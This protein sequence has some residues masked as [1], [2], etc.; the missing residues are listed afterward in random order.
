MLCIA[1]EGASG[2]K[3]ISELKGIN[4]KYNEGSK[5][6]RLTIDVGHNQIIATQCNISDAVNILPL[7]VSA[8][9]SQ[10][11]ADIKGK[12]LLKSVLN[13]KRMT[14]ASFAR[15]I[16]GIDSALKDAKKMNLPYAG[17]ILDLELILVDPD[18]FDP[19]LVHLPL[20]TEKPN[21]EAL[22]VFIRNLIY[23]DVVENMEGSFARYSISIVKQDALTLNDFNKVADRLRQA[24][25]E[26]HG[27]STKTQGKIRKLFS[28]LFN[29][30]NSPPSTKASLDDSE[31]VEGMNL[32]KKVSVRK[33]RNP[34]SD[35]NAT[36]H[37]D[38][39]ADKAY[40][41]RCLEKG[42]EGEFLL[43]ET[44]L[45]IGRREELV[46]FACLSK[47]V[48]RIHASFIQREG[49]IFVRDEN[50]KNRT[51]VNN[52]LIPHESEREIFPDDT[53]KLA[54]VEFVLFV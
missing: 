25:L 45:T 19:V 43:D 6:S 29:K 9:G 12:S 18:S 16:L 40:H 35:G 3:R 41:L 21:L 42:N 46:D 36:V 33:Q 52:E 15:F 22:R 7:C 1:T 54:D 17:F 4:I 14:P 24:L 34:L 26:H 50:S 49:K 48:G 5:V 10:L 27:N 2:M 38:W 31:R 28:P 39:V 11:Q 20:Y 32:V 53:I 37:I 23:D 30:K 8:D 13:H 44:V 47:S 51:Y